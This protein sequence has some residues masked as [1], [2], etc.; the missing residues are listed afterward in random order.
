[1][2]RKSVLVFVMVAVLCIADSTVVAL[3]GTRLDITPN[4][5][6][7]TDNVVSIIYR[8]PIINAGVI[9]TYTDLSVSIT[10]DYDLLT[11]DNDLGIGISDGSTVIGGRLGN[12]GVVY[13]LDGPE[14]GSAY[15]DKG[16]YWDRVDVFPVGVFHGVSYPT[17][18]LIQAGDLMETSEV[19]I[20]ANGTVINSMGYSGLDY[21]NQI[22]FVLIGN[23]L[24]EIYGINSVSIEAEVVPLPTAFILGSIGI[25]FTG[26]LLKRR[27]ML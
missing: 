16:A 18:F 20:S 14:N 5:G 13:Y 26:W 7:F 17:T 19:T 12:G 10:I 2:K 1:M 6:T 11:R 25:T 22:D 24:N 27:K 23:N 21:N 15:T 8:M 4:S 3:T 9:G